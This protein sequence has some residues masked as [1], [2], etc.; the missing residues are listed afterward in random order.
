MAHSEWLHVRLQHKQKASRVNVVCRTYKKPLW[1]CLRAVQTLELLI[2]CFL[3]N[4]GSITFLVILSKGS[5]KRRHFWTAM[6]TSWKMPFMKCFSMMQ[7]TCRPCD[8]CNLK[9]H[10]KTSHLKTVISGHPV[11]WLL[12]LLGTQAVHCM[13]IVTA[14]QMHRNLTFNQE[15][16]HSGPVTLYWWACAHVKVGDGAPMHEPEASATSEPSD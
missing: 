10:D 4:A 6:K 11:L 5:Q 12:Q 14:L 7:C 8:V 13:C 2:W 1:G 16:L 9:L 3:K 15:Q